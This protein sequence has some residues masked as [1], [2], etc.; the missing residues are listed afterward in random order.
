MTATSPEQNRTLVFN[1]FDT[2]FNKRNYLAAEPYRSP[3]Y[4]QHSARIRPGRDGLFDLVWS[5]PGTL[6]SENHEIVAEGDYAHGCF[7]GHGR[8]R[9]WIAADIVRF[10]DGKLAGHWDV[11]QDEAAQAE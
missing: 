10:E 2:L 11:L 5:L 1:A 8:R 4:V 3:A 7:S 9:S 6:R